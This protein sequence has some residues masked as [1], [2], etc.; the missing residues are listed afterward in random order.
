[1]LLAESG[2]AA[3]GGQPENQG[4]PTAGET[5]RRRG[6][7]R[8][9]AMRARA[10]A[11]AASPGSAAALGAVDFE[12]RAVAMEAWHVE[13]ADRLARAQTPAVPVLHAACTKP[14]WSRLISNLYPAHGSRS[15]PTIQFRET[16]SCCATAPCRLIP[17]N[18]C[19]DVASRC[20]VRSYSP[21]AAAAQQPAGP[22]PG[23]SD[24]GGEL[25][26]GFH[27]RHGG[28]NWLVATLL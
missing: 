1:M 9:A 12:S 18:W 5:P 28:G 15:G 4:P 21:T 16:S 26:K 8:K 25:V 3:T 23:A 2:R 11:A 14:D 17:A 20:C 7:R 19:C 6:K 27:H 24:G 22:G 10:A 13:A